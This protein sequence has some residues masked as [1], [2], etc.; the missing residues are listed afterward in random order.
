MDRQS[1]YDL[2]ARCH[3]LRVAPNLWQRR[4][5]V[6]HVDQEARACTKPV[7]EGLRHIRNQEEVDGVV[8]N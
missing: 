7:A 3:Y 4:D 5:K 2:Q 1:G 6:Q 8:E